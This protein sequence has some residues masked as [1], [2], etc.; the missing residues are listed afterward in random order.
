MGDGNF[1]SRTGAIGSW[2]QLVLVV[3]AHKK[4]AENPQNPG[5]LG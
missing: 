1:E 4:P 2:W 5:L 3:S